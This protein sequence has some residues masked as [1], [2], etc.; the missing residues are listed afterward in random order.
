ML[1]VVVV[2]VVKKKEEWNLGAS[3]TSGRVELTGFEKKRLVAD[4]WNL[5]A[6][7]ARGEW[8]LGASGTSGRV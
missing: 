7:G 2:V 8:N 3:G 5:E 4:G 1:F 6:N